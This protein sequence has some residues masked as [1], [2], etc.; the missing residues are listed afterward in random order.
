MNM[1]LTPIAETIDGAFGLNGRPALY[2]R[3]Y[4][5]E[6]RRR[7]AAAFDAALRDLINAQGGRRGLWSVLKNQASTTPAHAG[8]RATRSGSSTPTPFGDSTETADRADSK[9]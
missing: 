1:N 3:A 2:V 4:N 5:E 9:P 8:A 7:K 6:I